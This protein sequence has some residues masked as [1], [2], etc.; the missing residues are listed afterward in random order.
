ME[1]VFQFVCIILIFSIRGEMLTNS[2]RRVSSFDNM[3]GAVP[4]L[5]IK[6]FGT[7]VRCG[8]SCS[9]D[10]TCTSFFYHA[11]KKECRG[12]ASPQEYLVEATISENG[13]IYFIQDSGRV[14]S[15]TTT[16]STS[17]AL[18]ISSLKPAT[19]TAESTTQLHLDQ[20]GCT[21]PPAVKP[22][23]CPVTYIYKDSQKL[24]LRVESSDIHSWHEAKCSCES[25]GGHLIKIQTKTAWNY[26]RDILERDHSCDGYYVGGNALG[27]LGTWRWLDNTFVSDSSLDWTHH[28]PK[29]DPNRRCIF[30]KSSDHFKLS[31]SA[32]AIEYCYICQ[33]D[34]T[35]E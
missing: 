24:C 27:V 35:A 25:G 33:I 3:L 12:L 26:I 9:Y 4:Y 22:T 31:T 5:W 32:C 10:K 28:E 19:S 18:P 7:S 15:T 17:V 2:Y 11:K 13:W 16:F 6:A 29:N 34:L 20:F 14:S 8:F 23:T 1:S 21:T 30:L